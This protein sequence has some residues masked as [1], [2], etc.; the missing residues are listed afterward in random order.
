MRKLGS[1][2]EGHT[3]LITGGTG[4]F[5]HQMTARLLKIPDTHI[6]IYSRDEDKHRVMD[7][8]FKSSDIEYVLGDIRDY[9]RLQEAMKGVDTVLHAGA[10]KQI[11]SVEYNPMEAI[12]TNTISAYNIMKASDYQNVE[13]VIAISTDKACKPTNSYGMSK[14]LMEKIITGD[15]VW[16]DNTKFGC[17]R[18]GNVLGS[19]GSVLPVW[20]KLIDEKK[21]IPITATQMRRFF[22]TLEQATDLI[23]FAS[24]NL[25]EKEIFVRHSPALFIHDLASVYAELKTGKKNYP[26][27]I[28]GVRSGEKLDEVL[29][30]EEETQRTIPMKTKYGMF[31][32]IKRQDHS[33]YP[34]TT[35]S[36]EYTSATTDQLNKKEIKKLIDGLVWKR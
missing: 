15:D 36:D 8:I 29:V 1:N 27:K 14:A 26:Q 23:L 25:F 11:P 4:S 19:R 33:P 5:G 3:I 2:L 21:P 28:I 6:K 35:M 31:Y 18:Y 32:K 10:L 16:S 17:V 24:L 22:L 13:Q 30:A 34:E 20:D 12:K 9:E 7:N